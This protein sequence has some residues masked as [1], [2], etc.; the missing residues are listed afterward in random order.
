MALVPDQL[1]DGGVAEDGVLM[2]ADLHAAPGAGQNLDPPLA[3]Q[4]LS[5]HHALLALWVEDLRSCMAC[6]VPWAQSLDS[7]WAG[8][9]VAWLF[10]GRCFVYATV[11]LRTGS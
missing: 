9:V 2:L 4:I 1:L 6:L 8:R 11:I 10:G 7:P 3:G 5:H